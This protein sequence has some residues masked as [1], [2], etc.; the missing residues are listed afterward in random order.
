MSVR[1]RL[2]REQYA[3]Q[4]HRQDSSGRVGW[5]GRCRCRAGGHRPDQRFGAPDRSGERLREAIACN[6][7]GTAIRDRARVN[8]SPTNVNAISN[9]NL[10][11][12]GLRLKVVH[13]SQC[14]TDCVQLLNSDAEV[15]LYRV[16]R[17]SPVM[18]SCFTLTG[19]YAISL[20]SRCFGSVNPARRR[21]GRTAL[22]CV[23]SHVAA[24]QKNPGTVMAIEHRGAVPSA[25]T[26]V[27]NRG[28]HRRGNAE[29]NFAGVGHRALR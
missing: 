15:I 26:K 20:R 18:T 2:Q 23:I 21:G 12:D 6:G 28:G 3:C 10:L 16:R 19:R 27:M 7:R 13:V 4:R 5:R 8:H 24:K 29:R 11:D 9:K 1:S 25:R 14:W 22:P 17:E